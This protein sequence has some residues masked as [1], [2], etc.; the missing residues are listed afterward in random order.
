M[1]DYMTGK[2]DRLEIVYTKFISLSK[3]QAVHETLLPMSELAV[4]EELKDKLPENRPQTEAELKRAALVKAAHQK[5]AKATAQ[6]GTAGG[7]DIPFEFFP[8]AEST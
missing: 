7:T 1:E 3:Q 8:S 4:P 6:L 2:I 5:V